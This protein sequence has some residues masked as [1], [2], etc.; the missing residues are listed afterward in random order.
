M[1]IGVLRANVMGMSVK[2]RI[3]KSTKFLGFSLF[4]FSFLSFLSKRNV[5]TL[6]MF[7]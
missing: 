7:D 2:L 3:T 4:F 6:L 5:E 1:E